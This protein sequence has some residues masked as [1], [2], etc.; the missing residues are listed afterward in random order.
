[1][2]RQQRLQ[3]ILKMMAELRL[4]RTKKQLKEMEE[5]FNIEREEKQMLQRQ[6]KGKEEFVKQ[7]QERLE[8]KIFN[9]LKLLK[10][11]TTRN[12]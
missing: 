9:L 6:L 2:E 3:I 10:L 8:G 4:E 11:H 5:K 7:L 1:M 12:Y